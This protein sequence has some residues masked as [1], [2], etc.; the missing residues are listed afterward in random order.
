MVLLS[1]KPEYTDKI[2][3]GDKK[4]EFRKKIFKKKV[5]IVYIYSS[6]PIKQI[7]GYFH[8]DEIIEDHPKH[9]WESFNKQAG[10]NEF[11]FFNYF[12]GKNNGF[13]IKI[14]KLN[15][16]D[17]PIDPKK[18]DKDF[19]PPQSFYYVNNKL[20]RRLTRFVST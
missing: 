13:A 19:M 9:L 5:D 18:I 8:I 14:G 1:I 20:K 4:F 7:I 2:I 6:Y 11:D 12:T 10:I 15:I 16:F 17:K 3:S